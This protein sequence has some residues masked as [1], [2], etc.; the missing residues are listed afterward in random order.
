MKTSDARLVLVGTPIGNPDDLGQR[1]RAM[2]GAAD[3]LICED[4]KTAARLFRHH[5][6]AFPSETYQLL[7]E[8]TTPEELQELVEQ[9]AGS[10]LSVLISDAGMPVLADPGTELVR[11]VRRRGVAVEVVPGPTAAT[12]A[13]ARAGLGNQS[14]FF[15]GFCPRKPQLRRNF[16]QKLAAFEVPVVLY[17]APYRTKVLL[18]EIHRVFPRKARV[19]VGVNLTAPGEVEFDSFCEEIPGMVDKIPKGPPVVIL[20]RS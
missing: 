11:A 6:L 5:D 19:Y 8:H 4:R 20:Y 15:A 16:L 10:G 13:L 9:V 14:Y 7:N 2:L 18:E 17:E 1:A 3:L 12:T